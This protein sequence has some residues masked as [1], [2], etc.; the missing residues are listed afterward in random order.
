MV[1][2][3]TPEVAARGLGLDVSLAPAVLSG[4]RRLIERL[5]SNLIENAIR[6]NIPGGRIGVLVEPR[7]GRAVLAVAN[8]GP[9]V[10]AGEVGRLMAPFQRMSTDRVGHGEG[11]GLGLSIVAAIADA[12]GARLIV[13]P[14]TDGGLDVEA[15]FPL[16]PAPG[17]SGALRAG[18]ALSPLTLGP[19]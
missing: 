14:G 16:M 6:H 13:S 17:P 8:T 9:V 7:V 5:V 11:I 10:P 1:R 3:L 18:E 15:C 12:H 2:R 4:D 19:H